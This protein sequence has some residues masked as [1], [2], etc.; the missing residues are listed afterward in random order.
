MRRPASRPTLRPRVLF[1]ETAAN[2]NAAAPKFDPSAPAA[3]APSP[4]RPANDATP[5]VLQ[6]DPYFVQEDKVIV[7]RESDLL[8]P[9]GKLELAKKRQPGVNID[10][11]TGLNNAV[12]LEMLQEDYAA[13]RRQDIKA[14]S[15]YLG[16]MNRLPPDLK[17]KADEARTRNNEWSNQTGTPFR[18]R[19]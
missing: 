10:P 2:L 13:G 8:T 5:G 16:E 15:D 9:E 1:S 4:T 17:R 7:L 12:A 3:A 14:L 6:L 11:V 19:R 18:E